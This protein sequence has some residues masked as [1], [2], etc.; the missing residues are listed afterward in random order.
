MTGANEPS[1][2]DPYLLQ[3]VPLPTSRAA[4]PKISPLILSGA[5]Q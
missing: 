2:K 4:V 3:V 1:P 5:R